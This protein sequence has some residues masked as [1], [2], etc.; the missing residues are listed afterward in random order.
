MPFAFVDFVV[1]GESSVMVM[2]QIVVHLLSANRLKQ[3]EVRLIHV[4]LLLHPFFHFDPSVYCKYLCTL[5][6]LDHRGFHP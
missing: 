4:N 1:L 6:C 5:I 2:Y 3:I